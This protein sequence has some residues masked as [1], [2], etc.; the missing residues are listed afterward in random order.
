MYGSCC[1]IFHK[2]K[3]GGPNFTASAPSSYSYGWPI[4]KVG[5]HNCYSEPVNTDCDEI[6]CD[7]STEGNV[8]S[9]TYQNDHKS[10]T[11]KPEIISIA[12]TITAEKDLTSN[13]NQEKDIAETNTEATVGVETT[14][15]ITNTPESHSATTESSKT[16]GANHAITSD[17]SKLIYQNSYLMMITFICL[18]REIFVL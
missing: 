17:S 6:G 1:W 16:S 2:N 18:L 12:P 8:D 7:K 4:K 9:N 15:Y 13:K 3:R 14:E 10:T 11:I 5:V